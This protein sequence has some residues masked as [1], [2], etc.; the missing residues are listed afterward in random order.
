MPPPK[1]ICFDL[2]RVLIRLC[3][4]WA[5]ACELAEVPGPAGPLPPD[6]HARV[7]GLVCEH[8]SGRIDQAEFC[9]RMSPLLGISPEQV[10]RMSDI[11]L[12]DVY[13]G[14]VELL[15]DLRA[16]GFKTACLSNT[17]A[18]H[19]A[20]MCDPNHSAYLPFDLF[21]YT[22]GSHLIGH[23]KPAMQI[24]QHVEQAT[25]FKGPQIIFFDD[26]EE[27]VTAARNNGWLAELIAR[28]HQP[29]RQVREHLSRHGV[30]LQVA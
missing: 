12:I 8:E 22:F 10:N 18:D 5:H 21:D 25:G 17:N 14:A 6:I 20:N 3:D 15:K 19:W 28:D 9:R 30:L 13:P 29:I 7:H 16:A 11:F 4:T 26:I 24:Y 1:L 23:R 2:G 27:N